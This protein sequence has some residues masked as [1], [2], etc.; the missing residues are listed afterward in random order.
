MTS[1]HQP[2]SLE[3]FLYSSD[4]EIAEVRTVRVA[5]KGS[6]PQCAKV[7]VQGVPAY[8]VLDS[9]ADITVM[10]GTLFR[11]WPTEEARPKETRQD[12][13]KLRQDPL[14]PRRSYGFGH[15]FRWQDDVYPSVH[16]NR[17]T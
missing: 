14:H 13:A 9:G 7:Q 5:D 6:K 1:N 17:C 10:G 16:Q 3:E 11:K 8:G 15:L 12:P 2:K 4:E